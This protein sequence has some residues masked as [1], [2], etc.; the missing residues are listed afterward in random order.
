MSQRQMSIPQV[1][2]KCMVLTCIYY[3]TMGSKFP[4][5]EREPFDVIKTQRERERERSVCLCN[6]GRVK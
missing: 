3:K 6:R 5:D 2:T 1:K 4:D